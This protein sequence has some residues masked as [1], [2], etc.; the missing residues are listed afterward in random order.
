M[1]QS[2]RL[3]PSEEEYAILTELVEAF[4]ARAQAGE[5]IDADAYARAH[6]PYEA[7]LRRLLPAVLALADL[8]ESQLGNNA[9]TPAPA[10]TCLPLERLGDFRLLR[11][12]GRGGMGA[13]YEAEQVSLGR[14]V[15]VKVL[16]CAAALDGRQL[17][18]FKNEAQAAAL[19]QH[20][21]IV[22]VIAVGCDRGTH[23]FAMQFID[24]AS[25]AFHIRD[26]RSRA[27]IQD[28]TRP[29]KKA[30]DPDRTTDFPAPRPEERVAVC[31][32]ASGS[33]GREGLLGNGPPARARSYFRAVARLGLQAAEALEHAHQLGVIHRDVKP[34]NLL[35]DGR[36]NL[37]VT[38][39]G[40]ARLQH[41]AG[42]TASGDLVGTVRYMSP[43]QAQ[44]RRGP[45]D[46]RTDVYA[47]GATLYEL[48]TLQP[49]FPGD[50]RRELLQRILLEDPRRPRRVNAAVPADLEAIV[51]KAME[52]A[53]ADRYPT[54]Q[55]LA[56]DLKR[57][58]A[59][60][61][62]R[63]RRPAAWRSATKWAR[64][65]AGVVA[66]FA[67]AVVAVVA[68]AVTMLSVR[69]QELREREKQLRERNAELQDKNKQLSDKERQLLAQGEKLQKALSEAEE[70]ADRLTKEQTAREKAVHK[71]ERQAQKAAQTGALVRAALR[72]VLLGLAD[73]KLQKDPQWAG[74]AEVLLCRGELV[75][76]LLALV[77][78]KDK[79]PEVIYES[80]LGFR[81]IAFVYAFLGRDEPARRT[82]GRAIALAEQLVK[83]QP[84][85]E[86]ARYLLAGSYRE[87]GDLHRFMGRRKEALAAYK[88]SLDVWDRPA[89]VGASPLEG[90]LAH[91]GQAMLHEQA[92]DLV[93]AAEHFRAAI[94]LREKLAAAEPEVP[95]HRWLL[96]YWHGRLGLLA[97][98]QAQPELAEEHLRKAQDLAQRL[99]DEAKYDVVSCQIEVATCCLARGDLVLASD[100]QAAS[101][102]YEQAQELLSRLAA[103]AP[104]IPGYRHLLAQIHCR[105]GSLARVG[106]KAAQAAE[107]Y[108]KAHDLLTALA[109][110]VPGGG[111]GPGTPGYNENALALFLIYCPDEHFRDCRRAVEFAR[112][113]VARA[114]QRGDYLGTL[115]A[116]CYRTG[117]AGEAVK[118][119]EK[120]VELPHGGAGTDWF[121]LALAHTK[122][123]NH[124][125]ARKCYQKALEWTQRHKPGF[126]EYRLLCDEA[127]DVL[128]DK[129][130]PATPRKPDHPRTD[131]KKSL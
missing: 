100:P 37:W 43:E 114:P 125:G 91:D 101:K 109:A 13:V 80:A 96:A 82:W 25:L 57:Y 20:P 104:G 88:Q 58:L 47:L 85:H 39:F 118:A 9:V 62:V 93:Q 131:K 120:A 5:V 98:A 26:L 53:P 24:G 89:P 41:D 48:L 23:F 56:D 10:E 27:R 106:Q 40:L 55:E 52:K 11:E 83:D 97:H 75:Y 129:D 74:K 2:G 7:E 59:D 90:S 78:R 103:D 61:S 92:G 127:A 71:A 99:L 30:L 108:R 84:G 8:G 31:S 128:G 95:L 68:V 115:G 113:A 107:H 67:A 94:D 54:A 49:A 111:P 51:L 17:Q 69:N 21:N 124:E 4:A 18:R 64:R 117:D 121:F 116:A 42:L 38:D 29:D 112:K 86:P 119:L 33:D 66:T 60:E 126:L 28:D 70:T 87:L 22:P 122:K 130:A 1:K 110:D 45:V 15:A 46:H 63:A 50:D 72:D 102:R 32:S 77:Q 81:Q 76:Q 6:P 36:G 34:A 14:R 79:D 35:V 12:I 44:S 123:G 73:Q 16:P 19:L 65:H 3:P 105:L